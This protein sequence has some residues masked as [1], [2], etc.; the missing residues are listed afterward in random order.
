MGA[1][2]VRCP[3]LFHV[4]KSRLFGG[5]ITLADLVVRT[6]YHYVCVQEVPECGSR[7]LGLRSRGCRQR[8][9]GGGLRCASAGPV[10]IFG[11][12]TVAG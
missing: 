11:V 4:S 8:Q 5:D 9:Q 12:G 3:I 10:W 2:T 1:R 7:T 6:E